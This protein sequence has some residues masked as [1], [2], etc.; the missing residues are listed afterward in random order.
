M[1][2]VYVLIILAILCSCVHAGNKDFFMDDIKMAAL[3][4]S[5]SRSVSSE[6][7][8]LNATQKGLLD[9]FKIEGSDINYMGRNRRTLLHMAAE[10]NA[11]R[12]VEWLVSIGADPN[13]PVERRFVC[14]KKMDLV[15][16]LNYLEK[17]YKQ[18]DYTETKAVIKRVRVK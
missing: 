4:L 14:G 5:L 17:E 15:E 13:I 6:S 10:L 2:G 7:E 12:L 18:H 11:P 1:K 8:A 9:L 3:V 16:Y